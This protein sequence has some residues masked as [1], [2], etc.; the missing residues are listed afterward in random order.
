MRGLK[1]A[2]VSSLKWLAGLV[3]A[4]TTVFTVVLYVKLLYLV[5]VFAWN[6]I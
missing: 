6:L 5:G 3:I 2:V 4:M 1:Y